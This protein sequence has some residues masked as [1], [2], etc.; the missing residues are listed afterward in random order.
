[1]RLSPVNV[2][3]PAL[4]SLMLML[5]LM[6]MAMRVRVRVPWP[7]GVP[8]SANEK[9]RPT[10]TDAKFFCCVAIIRPTAMAA[11]KPLSMFTTVMPDAQLVSMA[12]SAVKP[13]RAVP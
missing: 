12:N 4:L 6:L 13:A 2:P 5:M 11:P 3:V 10:H 1:V 9:S 8:M 7:V